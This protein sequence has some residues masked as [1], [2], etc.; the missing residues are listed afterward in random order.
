M[1][2]LVPSLPF[3]GQ[4]CSTGIVKKS[5]TGKYCNGCTRGLKCASG[6]HEHVY[7]KINPNQNQQCVAIL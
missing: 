6:D 7:Y 2:Q 1:C 3:S 4:P 5:Y